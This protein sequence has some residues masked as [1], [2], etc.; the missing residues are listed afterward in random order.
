MNKESSGLYKSISMLGN[1][2][3]LG[4]ALIGTPIVFDAT[5]Q[6]AFFYLAKTWGLSTAEILI[7]VLAAIEAYV[8]YAA[9]SFIITA[10]IVWL[11]TV[12]ATRS[13]RE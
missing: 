8:I 11:I 9:V 1:A 6:I 4:A 5:Q 3:A 10:G 13:F 12:I 7:W 2:I